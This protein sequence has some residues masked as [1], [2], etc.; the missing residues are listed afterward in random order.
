MENTLILTHLSIFEVRQLFRD[1]LATFFA[2]KTF[3]QTLNEADQIGRIDLAMELTGLAK[4]TIYSLCSERK[5]PHS[6]RGKRLY[7]S[8]QELT[9]WLKQ[10]KRKTQAEIVIEATNFG[11]KKAEAIQPIKTRNRFHKG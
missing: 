7:F 6:K 10:G 5:I 9:E 4:P 8:R 2:E 11:Q 1:E 3:A